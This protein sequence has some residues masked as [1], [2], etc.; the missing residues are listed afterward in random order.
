MGKLKTALAG[1]RRISNKDRQKI[2]RTSVE[3][4][5]ALQEG[6]IKGKHVDAEISDIEFRCYR[7]LC[8]LAGV[9]RR[10]PPTSKVMQIVTRI[11]YRESLIDFIH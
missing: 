9:E 4:K 6:F 8:I 3:L 2:Y 1:L 11:L 5:K 7:A 10:V